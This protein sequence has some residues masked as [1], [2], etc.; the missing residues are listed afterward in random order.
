MVLDLA[1]WGV[2]DPAK[3]DFVDQPPAV[4]IIEARQLLQALGTLDA[5]GAL[6]ARGQLVR[7]LALP[8]RLA[9]MVVAANEE[10]NAKDASMLAVLLT[11]QGLGGNSIDLEDRLRRFKS[12]RSPRADASRK[13]AD[14]IAQTLPKAEP[15]S[16][17][18]Q[19]GVILLHAFPDRIAFQRGGRGRFVMANGRG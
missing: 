14:R 16:G 1:H 7:S 12:D 13:L 8:P 15:S 6:T 4:S 19:P 18:Q 5:K 11:E 3:P 9:S 2:N 10:G 17:P